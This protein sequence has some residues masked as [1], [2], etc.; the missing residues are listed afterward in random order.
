MAKKKKKA[1]AKDV[2]V[3]PESDPNQRPYAYWWTTTAPICNSNGRK[4]ATFFL[5][6]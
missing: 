2:K 3:W 1:K 6:E 5:D 4:D